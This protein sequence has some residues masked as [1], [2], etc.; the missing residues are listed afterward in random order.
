MTEIALIEGGQD[1]EKARRTRGGCYTQPWPTEHGTVHIAYVWRR[2]EGRYDS[3]GEARSVVLQAFE[4]LPVI[5]I[6]R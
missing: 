1:D 4:G 5:E 3:H 2:E 6:G